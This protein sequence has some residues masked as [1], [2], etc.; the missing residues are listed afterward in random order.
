[1]IS[2][3]GN[4]KNKFSNVRVEV[5][6]MNKY[7]LKELNEEL[8]RANDAFVAIENYRDALV[9]EIESIDTTYVVIKIVKIRFK[10]RRSHA[11][12]KIPGYTHY[13]VY[14]KNGDGR[15][16]ESYSS[17]DRSEMLAYKKTMLLKYS[18][19][20]VEEVEGR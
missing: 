4:T 1:M 17:N 14:V 18:G 11:G 13:D 10:A 3:T 6:D 20:I 19:A 12:V 9:K 16:L 15:E 7:S 5:I 8:S 2:V